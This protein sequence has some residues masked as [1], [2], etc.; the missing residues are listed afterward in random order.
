MSETSSDTRNWQMTGSDRMPFQEG[1]GSG[2]RKSY[3]LDE[4]AAPT[5]SGTEDCVERILALAISLER[6]ARRLLIP[7]LGKLVQ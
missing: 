1:V 2:D 7:S 6:R 3:F 4:K 5:I